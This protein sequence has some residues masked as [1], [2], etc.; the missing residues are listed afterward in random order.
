MVLIAVVLV[1]QIIIG[2]VKQIPRQKDV[3]FASHMCGKL[4]PAE[5]QTTMHTGNLGKRDLPPVL[6]GV[7]S[8]TE[9]LQIVH[10]KGMTTF[11][12]GDD[13]IYSGKVTSV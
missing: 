13:M 9:C 5:I 12:Q 1:V 6:F 3:V 2:I 4:F 7:T 11:R 8:M 10:V